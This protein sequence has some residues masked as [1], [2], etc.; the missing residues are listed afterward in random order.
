MEKLNDTGLGVLVVVGPEN[1][2]IGTLSD[3]DIR[4]II[5]SGKS[6]NASVSSSVNKSPV[7]LKEKYLDTHQLKLSDLIKDHI[8]AL[9]VVD[10]E[11]ILVGIKVVGEE[12]TSKLKNNTVMIMAGGFGTRL[13]P[14]TKNTPKPM[15]LV[16]DKPILEWIIRQ[17]IGAGFHQFQVSTHYKSEIIK[18]YFGDGSFLGI[19]IQY[20]NEKEPL[21]TAGALSLLPDKAKEKPVIVINGDVLTNL[22]F[23]SLLKY[24]LSKKSNLTVCTRE[25]TQEVPFGVIE[26]QDEMLKS[27]QEKPVQ[28]YMVNAGI[29]VLNPCIM[30]LV[31]KNQKL[32]MPELILKSLSNRP[33]ST[34]VYPVYEYWRDIGKSD[35]LEAVN[36]N[37]ELHLGLASKIY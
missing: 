18:N 13:Y 36:K 4:R 1:R 20:I 15:L 22:N 31:S 29:Y 2:M 30:K 10:E 12:Q 11:N 32:D 17:F 8:F 16:N 26:H 28:N 7:Y 14:L 37:D 34:F 9:P 5:I 35:D 25:Y 3:G 33:N 24:H 21:G 6:T 27:I 19:S 23:N